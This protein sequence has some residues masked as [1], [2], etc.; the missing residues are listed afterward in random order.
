MTDI[1][2]NIDVDNDGRLSYDEVYRFMHR[3]AELPVFGGSIPAPAPKPWRLLVWQ[4]L[5]LGLGVTYLLLLLRPAPPSAPP[6]PPPP[7]SPFPPPSASPSAPPPSPPST[8]VEPPFWET[9]HEIVHALTGTVALV[10]LG[11]AC[12]SL[13]TRPTPQPPQLKELKEPSDVYEW[14]S[15]GGLVVR[16]R[17]PRRLGKPKGDWYLEEPTRRPSSLQSQPPAGQ[18]AYQA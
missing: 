11:L 5:L 10:I 18:A 4:K 13:P 17:L 8:P 14:S 16:V 6:P 1:F 15:K 9:H 3:K 7:P 12:A 2:A